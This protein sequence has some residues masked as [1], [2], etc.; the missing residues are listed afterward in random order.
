MARI[1]AIPGSRMPIVDARIIVGLQPLSR[2]QLARPY[3]ISH[4][5]NAVREWCESRVSAYQKVAGLLVIEGTQIGQRGVVIRERVA[6]VQVTSAVF[7]SSAIITEG[8]SVENMLNDLAAHLV[9]VCGQLKA[10]IIYSH[11]GLTEAWLVGPVADS[12]D[13]ATV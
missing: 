13:S 1:D 3:G 11:N 12:T 6:V 2:R 10:Q 7:A 4:V 5:T 8:E 9:Q